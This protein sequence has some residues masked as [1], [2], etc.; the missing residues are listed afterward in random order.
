MPTLTINRKQE[1]KSSLKELYIEVDGISIG[2]M[3]N[4][5]SKNFQ[6]AAGKHR[7][8]ITMDGICTSQYLD[9]EIEENE[10]LSFNTSHKSGLALWNILFNRNNY[11]LLEKV[12]LPS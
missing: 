4:G 3:L 10:N 9:I 11:F 12:D 8:R 1:W 5:E 2:S 6:I 7:I